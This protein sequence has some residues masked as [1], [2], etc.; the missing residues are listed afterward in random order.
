MFNFTNDFS[1][2]IIRAINEFW[3]GFSWSIILISVNED[4]ANLAK[5]VD[6]KGEQFRQ[7]YGGSSEPFIVDSKRI[8]NIGRFYNVNKYM[9][10]DNIWINMMSLYYLT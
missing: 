9:I 2:L 3:C 5:I 6:T 7:L 8:G 1:S 10:A 4:R